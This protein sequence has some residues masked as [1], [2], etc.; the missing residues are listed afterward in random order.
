MSNYLRPKCDMAVRGNQGLIEGELLTMYDYNKRF[1]LNKSDLRWFD[2]V[3]CKKWNTFISF[4]MRKPVYTD[5][6]KKLSDEEKEKWYDE[7][8]YDVRR[9]YGQDSDG[10]E[11]L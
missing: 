8:C 9:V 4:G 10:C 1:N 11:E 5:R 7:N 6:V 2:L 3:E